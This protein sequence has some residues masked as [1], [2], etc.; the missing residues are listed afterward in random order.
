[1]SCGKKIIAGV[2]G[3]A[4]A[5][6]GADKATSKVILARRAACLAC[7]KLRPAGQT[8]STLSTC[9]DC[10]CFIVVKTRM[11]SETCDKWN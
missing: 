11:A 5:A 1:V 6:V 7:E 4:R 8:I 9:K 2:A 10:G 3:L